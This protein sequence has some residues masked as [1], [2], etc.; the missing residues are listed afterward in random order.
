ME[1]ILEDQSI[2]A[3][4]MK[5]CHRIMMEI[6]GDEVKLLNHWGPV[7]M[8]VFE[9]EYLYIPLGYK[10]VMVCERGFLVIEV[11]DKEGNVFWPMMIF[12]EARYYHF[13]DVEK[14]VIQLVELTRKAIKE[15]LI[16]FE[17][18]G[19]TKYSDV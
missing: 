13:A 4:N 7:Q 2:S 18:A 5:N 6:F 9:L 14:D 12:K 16:I 3:K 11:Q 19:T 15:N 17:P 8:C 1:L 10:I